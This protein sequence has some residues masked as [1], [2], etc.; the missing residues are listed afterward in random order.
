LP[1]PP[2]A[3][4]ARRYAV[5]PLAAAALFAVVRNRFRLLCALAS[6]DWATLAGL[7][8]RVMGTTAAPGAPSAVVVAAALGHLATLR[9]LLV[10]GASADAVD[11]QGHSALVVAAAQAQ[12]DAVLEL[13]RWGAKSGA[14]AGVSPAH[15]AAGRGAGEAAVA[16]IKAGGVQTDPQGGTPL[17]WAAARGH[18]RAV[19]RLVAVVPKDGQKRGGATALHVAAEA[20]HDDVCRA[21]LE[22]GCDDT[23]VDCFGQTA[24]HLACRSERFSTALVLTTP[25]ACLAQDNDGDFPIARLA[26]PLAR[27][28]AVAVLQAM[29][30]AAPG[31]AC[32]SDFTGMTPLMLVLD[33]ARRED[34]RKSPGQAVQV[35][36]AT[37]A[38]PEAREDRGWVAANFAHPEFQDLLPDRFREN[39]DP[40]T[41]RGS[42][43]ERYLRLRGGWHRTPPAQRAAVWRGQHNLHGA[44]ALLRE[45]RRVILLFGAGVSTA[46]G[47]PDFR[48]ASGIWAGEGRRVFE[49]DIWDGSPAGWEEIR[50]TFAPG[51]VC[52]AHRL[53]AALADVGMLVRCYTQNVDG[54]EVAAGVPRDRVVMCHGDVSQAVCMLDCGASPVS[55]PLGSLPSKL[56]CTCGAPLRPNVVFFGE[57]VSVER[58]ATQDFAECDMLI[59]A[60]TTLTVYPVA[61][62]V[63]RVGPQCARLLVNREPVGPWRRVDEGGAG[64]REAAVIGDIEE[65]MEEL[66]GLLGW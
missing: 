39:F 65:N 62:L 10:A 58:T 15:L 50:R 9:A 20:G 38:D 30:G 56:L 45:G 19:R 18:A 13:L 40:T 33:A 8:A 29:I 44:A 54:L 41:Q 11:V 1:E 31:L 42:H 66:M 3:M 57:G 63:N 37:N 21:L 25:T 22:A 64:Y 28:E 5:V 49:R 48:S 27:G 34:G 55:V 43:S 6:R 26:E 59:V 16:L 24:L 46:S 35:L 7:V 2:P 47:I 52:A 23:L 60:G 36:V 32:C 51:R 17:H 14:G 61:G 4:L 53:A 12:E